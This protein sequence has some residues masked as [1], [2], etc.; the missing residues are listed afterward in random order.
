MH[1]IAVLKMEICEK[2]LLQ[3]QICERLLPSTNTIMTFKM[4]PFLEAYVSDRTK[5]RTS[6]P[7]HTPVLLEIIKFTENFLTSHMQ[8]NVF[9]H[10]QAYGVRRQF[11]A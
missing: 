6:A 3:S 7:V 8:M 9:H 11:A 1:E 10:A 2:A 4:K 5:V